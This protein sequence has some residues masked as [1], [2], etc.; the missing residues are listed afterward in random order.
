M[1][2][3]WLLALML[4]LPTGGAFLGKGVDMALPG[5]FSE[6]CASVTDRELESLQKELTTSSEAAEEIREELADARE[7]LEEK[8]EALRALDRTNLRLEVKLQ[9]LEQSTEALMSLIQSRGN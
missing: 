6:V 3:G 4:G 1:K 7:S 5:V 2:K 8:E 9:S